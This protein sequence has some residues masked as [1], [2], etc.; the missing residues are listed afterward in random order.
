MQTKKLDQIVRNE[1]VNSQLTLHSYVPFLFYAIQEVKK[2]SDVFSFN[3]N[4]QELSFLSD[5]ITITNA[6]SGFI[7]NPTVNITGGGQ[8]AT[9]TA[10]V[11]GGIIETI[12]VTSTGTGYTEVPII[13]FTTT[14]SVNNT[15]NNTTAL[16]VD[17]QQGTIVVGDKVT[18]DGIVGNVTVVSLSDQDNLVLSSPQSLENNKN[19]SFT[20]GTASATAALTKTINLPTNCRRGV[21]VSKIEGERL[22][23]LPY[24]DKMNTD[25]LSYESSNTNGYIGVTEIDDDNLY[26]NINEVT[27]KVIL[28]SEAGLG[29]H[30]L[31]LTYEP[32]L[33]SASSDTVIPII[34]ERVI[35]SSIRLQ[36][37]K[38]SRAERGDV[39]RVNEILVIDQEYKNAKRILKT[40]LN[41]ITWEDIMMVTRKGIHNSIKN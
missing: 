26:Y 24:D 38:N 33:F 16:V 41:K 40:H 27:N 31:M 37:A 5:T 36:R 39:N 10:S 22:L 18:G 12:T 13:S 25:G 21:A 6:G 30:R 9:A 1:I 11:N 28:S 20:G 32:I 8:G 14:A 17:N 7:S 4:Q 34:F 23:P 35:Q 15:T 19:L 3:V 2:L 29:N